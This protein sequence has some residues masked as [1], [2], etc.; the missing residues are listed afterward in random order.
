MLEGIEAVLFDLDGTL[1]DSM[2]VWPKVDEIYL[3]RMGLDVPE[4]LQDQIEG[5]GFTEVARYFKERFH[6]PETLEQIKATWNQM[7]LEAYTHK[8]P[9]KSGVRQFLAA[10]QSRKIPMA[11]ASSNSRQLIEAVLRSHE[12]DRYF[13]CI[14]TA[15]EVERGKPAPDVYLA[16]ARK[17]SVNPSKCLV[18]EDIV[19]G[20][21][22]GKAAQMTTCAVEDTFSAPQREEKRKRADYYIDS[23]E[24]LLTECT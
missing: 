20:I 14:V 11:V 23:Y 2:W 12:I 15:C 8:V 4:N 22:A 13:D 21:L 19:A 10:L 16:A 7:A 6:I 1:V 3:G 17:L 5:M 9:L 18:F 24:E